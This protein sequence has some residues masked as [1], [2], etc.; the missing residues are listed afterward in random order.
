MVEGGVEAK[1]IGVI[2]PYNYQVQHIRHLLI[3]DG[4]DML[5]VQ[6]IDRY[7]VNFSSPAMSMET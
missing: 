4:L 5:E 6:T 3:P 2:S 7:Q 1:D